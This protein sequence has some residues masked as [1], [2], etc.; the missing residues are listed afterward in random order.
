[1]LILGGA[2]VGNIIKGQQTEIDQM[3][4]KLRQLSE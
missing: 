2:V 1:M 4:A 3:K